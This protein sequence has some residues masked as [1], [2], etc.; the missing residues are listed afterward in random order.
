[1]LQASHTL[2]AYWLLLGTVDPNFLREKIVINKALE[3]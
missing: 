3:L 1:M 2:D